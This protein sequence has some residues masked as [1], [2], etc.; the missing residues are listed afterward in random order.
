MYSSCRALSV[1]RYAVPLCG[2]KLGV[3]APCLGPRANQVAVLS[4]HCVISLCSLAGGIQTLT[5]G[6]SEDST[7]AGTILIL[8]GVVWAWATVVLLLAPASASCSVPIFWVRSF[9]SHGHC[10]LH[11]ALGCLVLPCDVHQLF[12]VSMH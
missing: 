5:E 9:S 6:D 11:T 2:F 7:Y 4:L 12:T 3:Q 10:T 1:H 8:S